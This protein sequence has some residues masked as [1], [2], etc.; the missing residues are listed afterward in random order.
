M[1]RPRFGACA[2]VLV[3]AAVIV[4]AY[5]DRPARAQASAETSRPKYDVAAPPLAIELLQAPAG[6][7]A[8]WDSLKGNAVVLEFWATWCSGCVAQIP[9]L[10]ELTAKFKDKAVRFISVTDEDRDV[11][12]AFLTKRPIAGWVGLDARSATFRSYGIEGRPQTALIDATGVLRGIVAELNESVL[13]QLLAGTFHIKEPARTPAIGT[14]AKAPLPLLNVIV[15]PAMPA[16]EVG[17]SPG[18]FRRVGT[19]YEAWGYDLKRML[20]TAYSMPE[21]RIVLPESFPATRYDLSMTLP[22]ATDASWKAMLRQI[23]TTAFGVSARRESWSADVYVLRKAPTG[24]TLRAAE[25]GRALQSVVA[26]AENILGRPV[27]DETGLTGKYNF[28][29]A[30]TND[31]QVLMTTVKELG[32]EL[33]PE[34]RPIEVL[35]VEQ[36]VP[37]AGEPEY[38]GKLKPE[39]RPTNGA[40]SCRLEVARPEQIAA[41]PTTMRSASAMTGTLKVAWIAAGLKVA[42]VEPASGDPAV[43][44]DFDGNGR[45]TIDEQL[46]SSKRPAGSVGRVVLPSQAFVY[47]LPLP[48]T[49]PWK[50]LPLIVVPGWTTYGSDAPPDVVSLEGGTWVEGTVPVDG[51][52]ILVRYWENVDPLTGAIDPTRGRVEMDVNADGRIDQGPYGLE[53]E[54]AD[55]KPIVFRVGGHYLSTKSADARTGTIVLR[56][57]P[58][59]DY[60]R[61]PFE[62]GLEVPDFNFVDF[63]G[64]TR[65]LS[66]FRGKHV[67]MDFW[68]TWCGPCVNDIPDLIGVYAKYRDR[69][70]E[71][72]GMDDELTKQSHGRKDPATATAAAIK[73]VEEKGATWPQ[74][75]TE[76]AEEISRRFRIGVHPTY[77]LLDPQGRIVSWGSTGQLPVRGSKLAGTLEKLLP[78]AK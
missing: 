54:M 69:G 13:D 77:I 66:E 16:P 78:P 46:A 18:A 5:P 31:R 58:A 8:S 59:S 65:K 60:T 7:Q 17:M 52:E 44:A 35:V 62:V 42:V 57:H 72:L 75:R 24:S 37:P 76:V 36:G 34:R 61:I 3:A 74:V 19:K 12:A 68:G 2:A 26:F 56:E 63:A 67:L 10:N 1:D 70:F 4:C 15:R 49:S 51:R 73:L 48:G 39:L 25:K 33:V 6:T 71:I 41:L 47:Q 28:V 20:A 11:V 38:I 55:G 9:H 30:Y 21:L 40:P 27:L 22:D 64:K 45:W 23:L 50:F 14:E 43:Y 53:F 32:L 29:L